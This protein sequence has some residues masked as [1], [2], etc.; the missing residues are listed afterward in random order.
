MYL[1]AERILIQILAFSLG[2]LLGLLG[3]AFIS[4]WLG[5]V[6]GFVA[7]GMIFLQ[8]A[9]SDI[10]LKNT[11]QALGLENIYLAEGKVTYHTRSQEIQGKLF[12]SRKDLV[13]VFNNAIDFSLPVEKILKVEADMEAIDQESISEVNQMFEKRSPNLSQVT[14]M[15]TYLPG[16]ASGLLQV[17]VKQSIFSNEFTFEVTNPT[18]WVKKIIELKKSWAK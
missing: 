12:L 2:P 7:F 17:T 9:F 1:Y 10:C 15:V 5:L 18:L 13:F 16:L 11:A 4:P 3:A 6:L 8:P 14:S